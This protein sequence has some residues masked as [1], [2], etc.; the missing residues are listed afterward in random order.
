MLTFLMPIDPHPFSIPLI[1]KMI[2]PLPML[3]PILPLSRVV[4]AVR[5]LH[6]SHSLS[7]P[8]IKVPVVFLAIRVNHPPLHILIIL[9]QSSELLTIFKLPESLPFQFTINKISGMLE[10]LGNVNPLPVELILKP[11]T[12]VALSRTKSH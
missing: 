9:H 10:L 1:R 2:N 12:F 11:T 5:V 4:T 6:Y 8:I 7:F 3:V